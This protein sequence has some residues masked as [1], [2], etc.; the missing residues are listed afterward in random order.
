MYFRDR[1]K[2]IVIFNRAYDPL[3]WSPSQ[4]R[5]FS[6]WYFHPIRGRDYGQ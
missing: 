6:L 5:S 4:L 2:E 1:M 3:G